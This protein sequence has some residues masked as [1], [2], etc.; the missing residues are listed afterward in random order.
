MILQADKTQ[1]QAHKRSQDDQKRTFARSVV[2]W[3]PAQPS[4]CHL[5]NKSQTLADAD[6]HSANADTPGA[7]ADTHMVLM[8][9]LI[10]LMLIL[11]VL[12]LI[13]I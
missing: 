5:R 1:T 11:L 10:V 7:D 6:T 4:F 2:Y 9:I 13:L 3:S 12:M 8:L